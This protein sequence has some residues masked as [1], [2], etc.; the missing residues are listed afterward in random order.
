MFC[1]GGPWRRVVI[2]F[3]QPKTALRCSTIFAIPNR[4]VYIFQKK[5]T[6]TGRYLLVNTKKNDGIWTISSQHPKLWDARIVPKKLRTVSLSGSKVIQLPALK[7]CERKAFFLN[8]PENKDQKKRRRRQQ[9]PVSTE[10]GLKKRAN[11][12]VIQAKRPFHI[13]KVGCQE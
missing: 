2:G 10:W 7:R 12:Q 6:Y 13:C 4:L 11:F 8:F 5:N 1:E 3:N 9:S